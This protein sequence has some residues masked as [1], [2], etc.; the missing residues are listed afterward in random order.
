VPFVFKTAA[1]DA[2]LLDQ[3]L[4]LSQLDLCFAQGGGDAALLSGE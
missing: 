3:C 1:R 4:K 2:A